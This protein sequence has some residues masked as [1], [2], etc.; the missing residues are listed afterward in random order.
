MSLRSSPHSQRSS[1]SDNEWQ[2]EQYSDSDDSSSVGTSVLPPMYSESESDDDSPAIYM[3]NSVAPRRSANNV[4]KHSHKKERI[5]IAVLV[6]LTAA[7]WYSDYYKKQHLDELQQNCSSIGSIKKFIL[8]N[9]M[10]KLAKISSALTVA[11]VAFHWYCCQ[12]AHKMY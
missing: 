2:S 5:A 11:A 9:D 4:S 8:K 12:K 7:L 3:P 6:L 1:R 10:Q